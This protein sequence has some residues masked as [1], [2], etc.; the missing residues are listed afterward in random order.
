MAKQPQ[1]SNQSKSTQNSLLINEIKDGVVVMNDGSLRAVVL[2]SAINFDLMS[3]AE[4]DAVEF[5]YQGFLNSLHFPIQIVVKS[6]KIDLDSYI[7]SLN[8]IQLEQSNPLLSE[9]MA[10]YIANIKGLVEEVNIMDKQFYI[11]VPYFP[12]LAPTRTNIVSG[13]TA[14]FK[15]INV[16]TVSSADYENSKRELTQRVQQV[17]NGLVQMGVRAIPLNT[18]ELVD[19]YYT[20]YN[21]DVAPNQKLIDSGQLQGPS[22]T[23][24]G[25]PLQPPPA[26]VA[27][28]P[29]P[30]PPAVTPPASPLEATPP[31]SQNPPQPPAG[32]LQ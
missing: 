17:T 5:S 21:P 13:L 7:E 8:K 16:I 25:G 11:V 28:I 30:Q 32:G 15:P 20:S 12:P 31:P 2:A 29:A 1:N 22:V 4:Q 6:Q 3:S 24:G 23:R 14:V 9:L 19:L 18:Q 26:P 27:T 10:D